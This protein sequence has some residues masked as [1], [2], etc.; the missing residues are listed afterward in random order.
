MDTTGNE[1]WL[2]ETR[3]INKEVEVLLAR[4]KVAE[5][6]KNAAA[7]ATPVENNK[8]TAAS[9]A[10]KWGSKVYE[11]P[12]SPESSMA[13]LPEELP[14]GKLKQENKRLRDENVMLREEN[15][16]IHKS[17]EDQNRKFA[18]AENELAQLR[19]EVAKITHSFLATV[20]QSKQ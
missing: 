14:G 6:A 2:T 1:T 7:V 12:P 18:K 15:S 9:K 17:T 19:K 11:S 5:S 8:N 16:A 13:K 10:N 20:Q 4:V 3:L